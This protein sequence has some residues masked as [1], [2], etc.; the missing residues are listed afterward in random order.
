MIVCLLFLAPSWLSQ[1]VGNMTV[2]EH[3]L[4]LLSQE[5]S[6]S[7]FFLLGSCLGL[8]NGRLQQLQ[9]NYPN[10]ISLQ[11]SNML[12]EWRSTQGSQAVVKSLV[13]ALHQTKVDENLYRDI[14][15]DDTGVLKGKSLDQ[16]QLMNSIS[17]S[18]SSREQ[19]V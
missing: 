15:L 17:T 1:Q 10:T 2:S 14:L 13:E 5:L 4:H 18:I 16:I 9:A 3:A 11:F 8:S 12:C 6:P 19:W 7:V